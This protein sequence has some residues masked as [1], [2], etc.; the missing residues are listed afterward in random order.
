MILDEGSGLDWKKKDLNT[1]SHEY[2]FRRSSAEG[3]S[4]KNHSE[5]RD[6]W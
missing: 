5:P 4:F 2:F 6:Q 1:E 3:K